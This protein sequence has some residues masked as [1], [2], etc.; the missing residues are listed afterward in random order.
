[1]SATI[2]TYSVL[3]L[4]QTNNLHKF[5]VIL[6]SKSVG[7]VSL[8]CKLTK[9]YQFPSLWCV[10]ALKVRTIKNKDTQ[11]FCT[12]EPQSFLKRSFVPSHNFLS[13]M[14]LFSLVTS[15]QKSSKC[16]LLWRTRFVPNK[17]CMQRVKLPWSTE[18]IY[19]QWDLVINRSWGSW[20]SWIWGLLKSVTIIW[21]F[22]TPAVFAWRIRLG[23]YRMN[24]LLLVSPFVGIFKIFVFMFLYLLG[25]LRCWCGWVLSD[26]SVFATFWE[27]SECYREILPVES[28]RF[29]RW[30]CKFTGVAYHCSWLFSC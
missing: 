28:H 18:V 29:V 14:V 9:A 20:Q 2:T 16:L 26:S 19:K 21:K 30:A 4:V 7:I 8:A 12:A 24:H 27:K 3:Y 25:G 11:E 17:C 5:I 13:L 23:I 15:S 10:T 22:E 6:G 1:M